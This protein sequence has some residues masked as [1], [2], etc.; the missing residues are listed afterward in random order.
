[1]LAM[2]VVDTL[3]HRQNLVARELARPESDEEL[4]ARLRQVYDSQ[5]IEV[6]DRVLRE[7]VEALRE[8][9]FTYQ[10]PRD[11]P[12]WMRIYVDRGAWLRRLAVVLALVVAAVLIY[13]FA[14]VAPR[15]ALLTELQTN[16]AAITE[17]AS[18]QAPVVQANA[19]LE[20]AQAAHRAGEY[21][22]AQAILVQLEELRERLELEY[23]LVI[24]SAD[25][26]GIWRVPDLNPQARNY[27]LIV[28]AVDSRGERIA[29]P[30]LN[31]ET[32]ET[33][34]VSTYGLGVSEATWDAVARDL[35]D[36]GIIQN[37]LVGSKER[38][39]TEPDYFVETTGGTITRW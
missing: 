37:D 10:P 5:G 3:R 31:E 16:H 24:T 20:Q 22:E 27:Y 36:D 30:V 18:S 7:G 26:I 33:E 38:G 28:E 19:M 17:V 32:G 14:V 35:E 39:E 6:S 11:V 1:M 23:D 9:R 4:I 13:R 12:F 25:E 29:L 2:D 15:E 21:D 34:R 8:N